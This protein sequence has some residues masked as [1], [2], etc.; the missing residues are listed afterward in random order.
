MAVATEP[1]AATLPL[2]EGRAG[3]TVRVH[4]ILTGEILSPRSW[5]ERHRGR[6]APARTALDLLGRT[7]WGWV[8]AP[9]WIWLPVP[10]FLIEHP[11]V[12]TGLHQS[13]ATD[14]GANMG[15]L[16]GLIYRVRMDREQALRFQIAERGVSPR[17]VQVVVMTHL[18]IDHAS[19]VSDFPEAT[20]VVDEREWHAAASGGAS[21]GYQ[22]RQF[23]HAFDW[24]TLD[25]SADAVESFAGF[26]RTF[27]LFGDG[28]VRVASTPG[29]TQGHQSLVLRTAG[30]EV[31][32][33][34]DA[35]YTERELRGE[36]LPLLVEDAHL[37]ARSLK[38][39]RSYLEQTP[40]ATV[41]T[42]HDADLWA[43]LREV[44]E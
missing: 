15:R 27:D 29:H 19:A 1:R 41:I 10:A 25:Y 2:A 42:G 21:K 26:A 43:R 38:E 30:G 3:S 13:C 11:I 4:P 34:G 31:L 44:Y 16:G 39:I 20:F 37:H 5:V 32:L 28:S 23:D 22:R 35:A 18:H 7:G 24:R 40:D 36:A 33:V 8:P 6:L 14:V 17:D 12:D 9:P